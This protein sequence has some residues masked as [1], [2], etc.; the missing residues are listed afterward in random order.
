LTDEWDQSCVDKV[1]Q[2]CGIQCEPGENIC[3]NALP[4]GPGTILGTLLGSSNDG[5]ASA[6]GNP[7]GVSCNSG[8]VWYSYTQ[9]IERDMLISTCTSQRSFA[10]DTVVSIHTG[11]PGRKNNE[12]VAND[13]WRLGPAFDACLPPQPDTPD[14]NNVDAAIPIRGSSALE[15]GETVL[16]RV[17]HHSD[18]IRNNFQLRVLPEPEAWLALVAGAGALGALSRRRARG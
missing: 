4:I 8:D 14:P 17:S 6:E 13:D 5:C 2:E 9:D 7:A 11:C 15:A 16:I 18:S 12:I 3:S 1:Q 10:I